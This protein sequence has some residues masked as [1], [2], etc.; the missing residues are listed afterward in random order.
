MYVLPYGQMSLWGATVITNLLS[1]IPVFGQDIVELVWGGFSVSNATLNRFFS[2]HYI[3]PF[4]LAALAAGHMLALH[5]HGFIF[6][7]IGPKFI[8][9]K[10]SLDLILSTC[11][12]FTSTAAPNPPSAVRFFNGKIINSLAFIIPKIKAKNRIGPHNEDI[13][14]V[15]VGSL[16]GDAHAEKLYN[17]GV[18]FRFRQSIK[19]K[20]YIHWLY[21]FFNKRGYCNN[22]LPSISIQKYGSA[23]KNYEVYYFNTYSYTNFLWLYRLF[24]NKKKK[25]IPSNIYDYITPLALAIWIMDDGTWKTSGV[26]IATNSFT[27]EEIKL[28]SFT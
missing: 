9:I 20:D 15:L 4:V 10:S 12:V 16:L 7:Q 25:M 21:D 23:K 17:G 26:R 3:L 13:I 1:A 22:N 11:P 14:S 6:E 2:L 18:R 24:Y 5:V 19:H 8:Y 28:L 27:L